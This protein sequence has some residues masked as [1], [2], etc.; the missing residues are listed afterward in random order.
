MEDIHEIFTQFKSEFPQ[1]YA[2]HER[3]GREIHE[4]SGSLPEKLRW[5]IKI[6]I[7]GARNHERAL[8]THVR[9]ARAAGATDEEIKHTLLL[10]ISTTGFPCF[11]KAYSVFKSIRSS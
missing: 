8:E 11:M 5:L 2:K 10:L 7:S 6:A 9:K 4:N 1:V 3:L